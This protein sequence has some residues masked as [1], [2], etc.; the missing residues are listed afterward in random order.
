M[1]LLFV[2]LVIV[3]ASFLGNVAGFGISVLMIPVLTLF[4][5]PL[6]TLLLVGIIHLANS[7]WKVILFHQSFDWKLLLAFGLPGIV[8][9]YFGALL[10]RFFDTDTYYIIFGVFLILFAFYLWFMERIRVPA[11]PFWALLGGSLSGFIAGMFGT[12]GP[13][14][15]A[16]LLV[17]KLPKETY[18]ATVGAIAL[19][20][21]ITRVTTYFLNDYA[22][23]TT[24]YLGLFFWIP[25]TLIAAL[26]AKW[27]VLKLSA[28]SFRYLMIT[29]L[30]LL[31]FYRLFDVFF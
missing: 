19:V 8:L 14:R 4:L 11:K 24:Y 15:S 5:S 27:S 29:M 23:D 20:V 7:L 28:S 22:L 3:V 1:E 13:I 16:F 2:T 31:G 25:L 26:L 17:F 9:S 21:D 10:P 12:G 30:F 18:L 6:E